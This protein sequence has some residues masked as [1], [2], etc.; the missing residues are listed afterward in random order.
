[1]AAFIFKLTS[2]NVFI[3][4]KKTKKGGEI[5]G[6]ILTMMWRAVNR[7]QKHVLLF[8]NDYKSFKMQRFV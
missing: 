3:L 6:E 8:L 7:E 1:M 2:M 5:V 4:S